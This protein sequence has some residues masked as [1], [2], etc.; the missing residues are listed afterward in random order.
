MS[1]LPASS[2]GGV[3]EWIIQQTY[4]LIPL[5]ERPLTRRH[6]KFFRNI[7]VLVILA[8][9]LSACGPGVIASISN[10]SMTATSDLAISFNAQVFDTGG[11][12]EIVWDFGDESPKVN[13]KN[14]TH[15]YKEAGT[16][17]ATVTVKFS[18]G[19]TATSSLQVTV[20]KK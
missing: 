12:T 3:F 13:I 20:P 17:T 9:I 15:Q 5:Q 6:M 18:S 10:S 16:Y 8:L 19:S 7:S 1:F 14:P 4:S 2:P 11:M